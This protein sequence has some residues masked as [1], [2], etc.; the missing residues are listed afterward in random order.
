M[1]NKAIIAIVVIVAV[2]IT[3]L[4]L[5]APPPEE[6]PGKVLLIARGRDADILDPARTVFDFSMHT[7]ALIYDTLLTYD[8][9]MN[10]IPLLAESWEL[11]PPYLVD[12][13]LRRDVKFHCGHPFNA[14]AV[15]YTIE[16]MGFPPPDGRGIPGSKHIDSVKDLSVEILDEYKVRIL[17]EKGDNAFPGR[18]ALEWFATPSSS[19]VC[20]VCAGEFPNYKEDYGVTF[21][22]GTGPFKFKEWVKDL[23]IVLERNDEYRWGPAYYNNR[24]PAHLAGVEFHVYPEALVKS[25]AIE[26]G[27]IHFA[28]PWFAE[29]YLE[30][31]KKDPNL[32]VQSGPEMAMEY[33]GFHTGGGRFGTYDLETDTWRNVTHPESPKEFPGGKFVGDVRVRRAI[34]YAIDKQRLIEEAVDNTGFPHYG[35]LTPAHWGYWEGCENYY[36]YNPEK[37]KELLENAG[38]EYNEELNR[39]FLKATGEMLKINLIATEAY[40]KHAES[41][42]F[43]LDEVGIELE[44]EI[45]MFGDLSTRIKNREHQTYLMGWNWPLADILWWMHY[46]ERVPAP[47]RNWWE[48]ENV[49]GELLDKTFSF[50][51][52]VAKPALIEV[53]KMLVEDCVYVPLRTR[54]Q[55]HVLRKEVKGYLIHPWPSWVWKLLDVTI[56]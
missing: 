18:Y 13:T 36:R 25:L 22:C 26:R 8:R 28:L 47:N 24:G 17:F 35:Y 52:E 2:V 38:F 30:K 37:A 20:P 43:M 34:A 16:R 46:P 3:A 42:Y 40:R 4:S 21:T 14:E 31:F 41:L 15:K 11:K 19:I 12:F 45:I 10:L 55:N 6:G 48:R 32:V 44:I 23:K 27:D 7:I 39:W 53:Q 49:T 29:G 51:P 50:D 33:L 56:E 5:R 9:E 54:V 1:V